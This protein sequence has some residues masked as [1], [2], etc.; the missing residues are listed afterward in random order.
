MAWLN[1]KAGIHPSQITQPYTAMQLQ[2]N[3]NDDNN[4][5]N[6]N[7]N[8]ILTTAAASDP[9]LECRGRTVTIGAQG[10]PSHITSNGRDVLDTRNGNAGFQFRLTDKDGVEMA[11]ST[12]ASKTGATTTGQQVRVDT[13]QLVYNI[14]CVIAAKYSHCTTKLFTV[15]VDI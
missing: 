12:Q 13:Y 5:N 7:N 15:P 9:T 11:W 3:N 14:Q 2:E 1:S 8:K 6:N 10:L 4:N